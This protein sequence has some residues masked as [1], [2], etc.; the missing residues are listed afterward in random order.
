LKLE[1]SSATRF[2]CRAV[3][4]AAHTCGLYSHEWKTLP[5]QIVP[6]AATKAPL[7]SPADMVKIPEGEFH[8]RVAGIELEGST[9]SGLM[10]NIRGKIHRAAFTIAP[11][12]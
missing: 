11:C 2:G 4:F 5:Q 12:T 7:G 6:I 3:N 9:T 1:T 10:C 8:F